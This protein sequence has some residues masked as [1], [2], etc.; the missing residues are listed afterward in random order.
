MNATNY[1]VRRSI[2]VGMTGIGTGDIPIR[3]GFTNVCMDGNEYLLNSTFDTV[4]NQGGVLHFMWHP[5]DWVR[6]GGETLDQMIDRVWKDAS[7][8]VNQGLACEGNRTDVWYVGFGELYLY[9]YSKKVCTLDA[10]EIGL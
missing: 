1:L 5:L 10:T 4:Y 6:L 2:N 7:S 9:Q 8:P 3:Y